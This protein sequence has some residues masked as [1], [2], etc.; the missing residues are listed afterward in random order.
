MLLAEV[1]DCAYHTGIIVQLGGADLQ[2]LGKGGHNGGPDFGEMCIRDSIWN[3]MTNTRFSTTLMTPATA[4][5]TS[6]RRVSPTARSR[7]ALKLYSMPWA[8]KKPTKA[9]STPTT[10]LRVTA[11]CTASCTPWSSFA[12]DVYKRQPIIDA[13]V[14]IAPN[15]PTCTEGLE[16]GYFC[17]KADGT[18]FVAAVW[19]GKAYFA[20]F[21]RP[22]VRELSLIHI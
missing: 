10:R 15:D 11:V 16:K 12:P 22:E 5:Q 19:P 14:R 18:P 20:D 3:T 4:R 7:E 2:P 1:I 17:K 6:G 13:G 8:A 21:L 9:I